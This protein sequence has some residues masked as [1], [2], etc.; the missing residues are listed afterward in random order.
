M[1]LDGPCAVAQVLAQSGQKGTGGRDPDGLVPTVLLLIL[2]EFQKKPRCSPKQNESYFVLG[3][4]RPGQRGGARRRR[5]YIHH[6]PYQGLSPIH[7]PLCWKYP[8]SFPPCASIPPPPP[9]G[10]VAP[11]PYFC[12]TSA[13]EPCRG[14]RRRGQ[15]WGWQEGWDF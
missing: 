9:Q 13:E 5:V 2:E 12:R 6:L 11:S 15:K 3:K 14:A 1:A 8:F 10:T 7:S 4:T